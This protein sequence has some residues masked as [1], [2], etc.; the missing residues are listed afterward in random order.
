M[1]FEILQ[2][3][4]AVMTRIEKYSWDDKIFELR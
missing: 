1:V 2:D 3:L 4:E